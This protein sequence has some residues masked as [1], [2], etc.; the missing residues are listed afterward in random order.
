M[1]D[2]LTL[3]GENA[4]R[5]LVIERDE[6]RAELSAVK[7][8]RD[9]IKERMEM[10]DQMRL[11]NL[12]RAL[13]QGRKNMEL[14]RQRA[15]LKAIAI[16]ASEYIK[17]HDQLPG[18][19]LADHAWGDSDYDNQKTAYKAR[20]RLRKLLEERVDLDQ[21]EARA[22]AANQELNRVCANRFEMRVHIPVQPDDTDMMI[23]DA[24]Q[25]IPALVAELRAARDVVTVAKSIRAQLPGVTRLNRVLDAY[26]AALPEKGEDPS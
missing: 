23:G 9:E 19:L 14:L 25:D 26:D 21:I 11:E 2:H 7:A 15:A 4:L 5:S 10:Y 22:K 3:V 12:D 18:S 16:A 13:E 20:E 6:L 17:A 8:E 24:L 1:S